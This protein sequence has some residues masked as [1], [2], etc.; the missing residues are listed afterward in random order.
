MKSKL[1]NYNCGISL[2]KEDGTFAEAIIGYNILIS[3]NVTTEEILTMFKECIKT[4]SKRILSIVRRFGIV[5]TLA[6]KLSN[7]VE[8]V[9]LFLFFI[10]VLK[11]NCISMQLFFSAYNLN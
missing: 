8:F 3:Q 9:M 5:N 6:D 4:G 7:C 1:V 10:Y 2:W 11:R